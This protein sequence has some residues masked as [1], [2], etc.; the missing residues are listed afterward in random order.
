M[1]QSQAQKISPR[2]CFRRDIF[3]W[4]VLAFCPDG[5]VST[6]PRIDLFGFLHG[7]LA[8]LLLSYDALKKRKHSVSNRWRNK[9]L[10]DA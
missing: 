5:G 8:G 1:K 6:G 2:K 9:Y 4:Y 3:G 7:V 10:K